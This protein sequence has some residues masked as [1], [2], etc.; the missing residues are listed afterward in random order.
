MAH[1]IGGEC[2]FPQPVVIDT[3]RDQ[4]N[5]GWAYGADAGLR[6]RSY[7]YIHMVAALIAAGNDPI[8]AQCLATEVTESVLKSLEKMQ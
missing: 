7:T 2:A 4:I 3:A 5:C 6:I 8:H 1:D